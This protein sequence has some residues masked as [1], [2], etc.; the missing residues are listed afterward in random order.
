M[1]PLKVSGGFRLRAMLN[2]TSPWF[3]I[4]DEISGDSLCHIVLCRISAATLVV[5]SS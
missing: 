3:A 5:P 4:Y 1:D 2:G